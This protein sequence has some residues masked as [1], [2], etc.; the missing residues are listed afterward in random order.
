MQHLR[1][2]QRTQILILQTWRR[3]NHSKNLKKTIQF[4]TE[5]ATTEKVQRKYINIC[6]KKNKIKF[7][8]DTGSDLC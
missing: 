2:A 8:I 3:E 6:L 5:Q 1:R 4:T 7:Q